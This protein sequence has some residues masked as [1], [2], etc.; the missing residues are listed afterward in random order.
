MNRE[1]SPPP[2]GL[3]LLLAL[4]ACGD[5]DRA[6]TAPTGPQSFLAGTWRGTMTIQ[7]D[8]TGRNRLRRH[9]AGDMDVRGR[10]ADQPADVSHHHPVGE[11][12]LPITLTLS[13]SMIPGNSR[14]RRSAPKATTTRREDA[15][16]RS[17]SFANADTDR[18]QGEI[19]G[20]DCPVPFTGTVTLTKN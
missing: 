13:T 1:T 6:P 19:T 2:L 12:W 10:A 20:V 8:P 9:G 17:A 3:L 4:A 14:R 16:A 7:P 5:G 18:I 15:E 11:R